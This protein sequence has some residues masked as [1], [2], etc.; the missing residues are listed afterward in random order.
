MSLML[1][2]TKPYA[3]AVA[4]LIAQRLPEG[5]ALSDLSIETPRRMKVDE[6]RTLIKIKPESYEK[7]GWKWYGRAE[8]KH[9]LLDLAQ[10]FTNHSSGI[11]IVDLGLNPTSDDVVDY[12][13]DHFGIHFDLSDYLS[14]EYNSNPDGWYLEAA[15]QSL[16]YRGR[17]RL[18]FDTGGGGN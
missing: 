9:G 7:E 1:L 14:A 10:L 16:R 15:P 12:I 2:T 17:V 8:F 11:V 13:F 3:E 4:D 5:M 6:T 18:N